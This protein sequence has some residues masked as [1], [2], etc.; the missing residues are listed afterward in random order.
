MQRLCLT[1]SSASG[2][3]TFLLY[4]H[5]LL[6]QG[7]S[8]CGSWTARLEGRPGCFVH[9]DARVLA[10]CLHLRLAPFAGALADLRGELEA[11]FEQGPG[12]CRQL[13]TRVLGAGLELRETLDSLLYL[14][15]GMVE[16]AGEVPV[17]HS[18]QVGQE[19]QELRDCGQSRMSRGLTQASSLWE[20]ELSTSE[21]LL[22]LDELGGPELV[23]R[24]FVQ[25]LLACLTQAQRYRVVLKP[26]KHLCQLLER[27]KFSAEARRR[28]V[29]AWEELYHV[30]G[31]RGQIWDWERGVKL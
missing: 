16:G 4:S 3:S 27:G 12:F 7:L 26:R 22:Y 18:W 6:G 20:A 21:A 28:A 9:A 2:K 29:E 10:S 14:P 19:A 1:G 11:G 31:T 8:C 23:D 17:L 30:L 24:D 13:L 5:W 15:A 25:S